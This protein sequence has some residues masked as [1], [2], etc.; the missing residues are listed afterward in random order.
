MGKT[1]TVQIKLIDDK[2]LPSKELKEIVFDKSINNRFNCLKKYLDAEHYDY[3][4]KELAILIKIIDRKILSQVHYYA[5][6]MYHR[7]ELSNEWGEPGEQQV[8]IAFCRNLLRIHPKKNLSQEDAMNFM[9]KVEETLKKLQIKE[10]SIEATKSKLRLF[11]F[12]LLGRQFEVF[13]SFEVNRIAQFIGST[14]VLHGGQYGGEQE[15]ILGEGK[16]TNKEGYDIY[17]L[18]KEIIRTPNNVMSMAAIIGNRNIFIRLE[19]LQTIFAQKWLQIFNYSDFEK[20]QIKDNVYWN[21]SEGI[22]RKVLKLYQFRNRETLE[23]NEKVFLK[24]MAETILYHELGHGIIQ[25]DILP[26]E[27]GAIGEASKLLGENIYTSILEFL[28]DF[29]PPHSEL[30]GPIHNMISISKKDKN[31]ATRMYYL[32]L[33]DTWFFNTDDTYMYTY[34]DLMSLIL[35]KYIEKDGSIAFDQLNKDLQF[36]KEEARDSSPTVFERIYDL[37]V[38][39]AKEIKTIIEHATFNVANQ[40]LGYNKVRSLLIEQFLENDGY[41]HEDTYEFLVPYWSNMFAYIQQ[42]SDSKTELNDF[43]ANQEVKNLKKILI[44]SCGRET[45][46]AYN[47]DHRKY[48]SERLL[49]LGICV[50]KNK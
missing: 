40:N 24:D 10:L 11:K 50:Y 37:Y 49:E 9:T 8:K 7:M 3:D 38:A 45:A 15:F 13:R 23:K 2:K 25:H 46:E 43:I 29:A 28:A 44:L 19:S 1:K 42:L 20:E 36:R 4:E 31:R 35:L 14:R 18:N 48:I 34:S 41:V 26:L 22:K 17:Y 39:D 21:I 47:F 33:S 5:H 27:L 32:Y 6:L 16:K 30:L 12:E